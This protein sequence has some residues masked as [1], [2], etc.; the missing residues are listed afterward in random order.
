M[1]KLTDCEKH[2]RERINLSLSHKRIE[3]ATIAII[4]KKKYKIKISEKRHISGAM[5]WKYLITKGLEEIDEK[6]GQIRKIKKLENIIDG[7]I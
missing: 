4:N 6:F 5:L 2:D 7:K 3:E 1:K